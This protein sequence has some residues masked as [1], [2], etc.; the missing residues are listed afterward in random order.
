[1]QAG[2]ATKQLEKLHKE[3]LKGEAE[4]EKMVAQQQASMQVCAC[5]SDSLTL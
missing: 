1:V 4:R 2:A 3:A 5:L